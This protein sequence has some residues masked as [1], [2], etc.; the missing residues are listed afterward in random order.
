MLNEIIKAIPRISKC[1]TSTN[2]E[3]IEIYENYI[4]KQC[5]IKSLTSEPSHF[6]IINLKKKR[7]HFI[8][9]DKC[10]FTDLDKFE[11]CDFGFLYES[12]LGFVEIKNCSRKTKRKRRK[13]AIKQLSSTLSECQKTIDFSLYRIEAYL[14]IGCK[15]ISPSINSTK[16]TEKDYFMTNFGASIY[17]GNQISI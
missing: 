7:F 3:Q 17:E 6:A 14:T 9:I 5:F 8:S 12:T 13:K 4:T 10:V 15:T 2:K 1:K 11:K 16:Q